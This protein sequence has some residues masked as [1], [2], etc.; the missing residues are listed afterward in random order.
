LDIGIRL[1]Q[2]KSLRD[3][4]WPGRWPGSPVNDRAYKSEIL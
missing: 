1:A 2:R 3:N 4:C